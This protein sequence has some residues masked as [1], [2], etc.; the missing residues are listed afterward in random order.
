MVFKL[1][2]DIFQRCKAP[3]VRCRKRVGGRLKK[4]QIL[5]IH[6]KVLPLELVKAFS[7][8]AERMRGMQDVSV[9]ITRIPPVQFSEREWRHEGI[10]SDERSRNHAIKIDCAG[11]PDIRSRYP[12]KEHGHAVSSAKWFHL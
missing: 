1:V 11:N 4:V 12:K 5:F 8:R 9:V 3:E 10:V 7:K 6:A 2:I